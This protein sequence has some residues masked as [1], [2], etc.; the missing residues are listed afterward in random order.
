M[1]LTD[2]LTFST[3]CLMACT[4]SSCRK[5]LCYNHFRTA[6]VSLEWEHE[7][8]R[9]YGMSH[10]SNWDEALHGFGYESLRPGR[11]DWVTMVTYTA[12]DNPRE[13][14][15]SAD[16]GDINVGDP[17][18]QTY[19]FYNND[20]EYIVFSDIASLTDARATSS[21]RSRTSLAY[22]KEMY[23][24][25]RSS[26]PPDVLYAAYVREAP[27]IG[28]HEARPLPVRMQPLV[29]TYVIRYEFE[30]GLEHV[31]L[32]RGAIAGM[33]ESVYLRNGVT[34]EESTIV[35]FDCDLKS[36]GAETHVRTFGVPGFPDEY[37]GRSALSRS[38]RPYTL[39][40]EVRLKNGKTYEFNYDIADQI[41]MQPRGGVI[42]I[43]GIRIEDDQNLS[44]SGFEVDVSDWGEHEDIDLPVGVMR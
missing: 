32:A 18:Q 41:A 9:D 26:N 38:D 19:L 20:T 33:A 34:S 28:L 3:V 22:I 10:S 1:K 23:P 8:E 30:H 7:W 5:D 35:L 12:D 43:T 31:A 17:T 14:F 42:R 40:L 37:Y 25:L 4:M 15:L 36:Y 11:P 39:N 16:G 44:D 13:D 27:Q 21:S 29:Y 2:I 24:A 6:S